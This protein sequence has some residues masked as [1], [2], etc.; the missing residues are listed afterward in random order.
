MGKGGKR[1]KRGDAGDESGG[2][3]E[4]EETTVPGSNAGAEVEP[5]K[6]QATSIFI[7]CPETFVNIVL[8]KIRSDKH[9]NLITSIGFQNSRKMQPVVLDKC[10]IK[11]LRSRTSSC[12]VLRR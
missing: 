10:T 9:I 1:R 12:S 2:G 3:R 6:E 5:V 7:S 8:S 4:E 11:Q